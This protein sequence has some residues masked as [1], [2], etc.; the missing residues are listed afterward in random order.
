MGAHELFREGKLDDAIQALIAEVRDN[1]D[2]R[3]RR[4]FLFELL[5][6]AGEY[7]RAEKQLNVL[8]AQSKEAQAGA[9]LY[10][11]ALHGEKTRR[12]TFEQRDYLNLAKPLKHKN[13]VGGKFN[14]KPVQSIRDADPR[15]G[16]R[17]EVFAAG[18]Y[19]WL[20]L[21]HIAAIQMEAPKRLRDL[22]WSPARI[23]T[24]PGFKDL[25]L[26]EFLLPALCPL[27][28]DH[29]DDQVRLGRVTEWCLNEHEEEVPYGSKILLVDGEEVPLLELRSLEIEAV[30]EAAT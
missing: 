6:F 9:L 18:E 2:D 22:L 30:Q 17:L 3:K 28:P 27:T 24:G 29:P 10:H 13:G 1:P 21:E 11:A 15:I 19:M 8:S 12:Q 20:P 7:D 23:K 26:G 4:T 5:C 25:D 16:A 14:G